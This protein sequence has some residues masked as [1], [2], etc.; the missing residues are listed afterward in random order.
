MSKLTQAFRQ[1]AKDETGITVV[2]G[3]LYTAV[4]AGVTYIA[5]SMLGG[6]VKDGAET[7][8]G[9]LEDYMTPD[10]GEAGE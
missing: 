5:V 6:H 9:G 2:E 7:L 1:F 8:G 3:F 10:W 4:A